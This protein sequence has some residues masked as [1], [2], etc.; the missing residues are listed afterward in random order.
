MALTKE[1]ISAFGHTS[2]DLQLIAC[3]GSG[4]NRSSG[5]SHR[6]CRPRQ[7][8]CRNAPQRPPSTPEETARAMADLQRMLPAHIRRD[9]GKAGHLS[10][11]LIPPP[12][13]GRVA[14]G[15]RRVGAAQRI[16]MTLPRSSLR[17]DRPSPFRGG[18]RCAR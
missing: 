7:I 12:L 2:G 14:S 10:T 11:L 5:S 1:Q 6:E 16:D 4:E 18:I 8:R 15:A 13:A 9:W 17:S 3:A